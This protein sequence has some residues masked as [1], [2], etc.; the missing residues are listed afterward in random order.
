MTYTLSIYDVTT[1]L[2]NIDANIVWL[3]L[4]GGLSLIFSYI[5]FGRAFT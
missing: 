5:Y 2:N 4:F 3:L 1:T